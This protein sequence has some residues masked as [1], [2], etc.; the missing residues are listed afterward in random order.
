[1]SKKNEFSVFRIVTRVL[2]IMPAR[3]GDDSGVLLQIWRQQPTLFNKR[4]YIVIIDG[5]KLSRTR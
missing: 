5:E 1:M 2:F 3:S 4:K